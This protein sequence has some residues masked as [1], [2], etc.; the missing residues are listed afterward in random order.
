MCPGLNPAA[1]PPSFLDAR[2]A[3]PGRPGRSGESW[4]QAARRLRPGG[5]GEEE[6][7]AGEG[8]TRRDGAERDGISPA[9][10]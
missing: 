3:A 6:A 9:A 8:R 2:L 10:A 4:S 1:G 5:M 7:A